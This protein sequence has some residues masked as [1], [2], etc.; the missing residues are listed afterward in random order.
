M[1]CFSNINKMF[2]TN[3]PFYQYVKRKYLKEAKYR[4]EPQRSFSKVIHAIQ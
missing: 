4:K 1:H 2:V 3:A